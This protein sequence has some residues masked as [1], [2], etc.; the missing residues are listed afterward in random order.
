MIAS[1]QGYANTT[2]TPQHVSVYR[3]RF[4]TVATGGPLTPFAVKVLGPGDFRVVA[5]GTTR[6]TYIADNIVP[7][8]EGGTAEVVLAPGE[9]LAAGVLG[10]RADGS[11]A[12]EP[13]RSTTTSREIATTS[14]YRSHVGNPA[15]ASRPSTV[16][17]C[18]SGMSR[19]RSRKVS[20]V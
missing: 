17:N 10:A 6:S 7:F 2:N 1:G 19:R 16:K 20:A 5:I 8:L 4:R 3:F 15:A 14:S 18:A 12:V 9:T 11:G 13:G